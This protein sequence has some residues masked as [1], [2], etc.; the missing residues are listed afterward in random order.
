MSDQD[1]QSNFM[2]LFA[3]ENGA[4]LNQNNGVYVR[5]QTY[6]FAKKLEVAAAYEIT[7]SHARQ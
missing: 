1:D 3:A 7:S 2:E 6:S 5:G 4:Y